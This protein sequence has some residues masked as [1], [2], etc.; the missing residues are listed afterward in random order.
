MT[1]RKERQETQMKGGTMA[2]Y[3]LG[4]GS[5][6]LVS[7]GKWIASELGGH[8]MDGISVATTKK[9]YAY[10]HAKTLL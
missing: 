3:G 5:R 2:L 9:P 6:W 1:V 7:D 4:R 10:P 8:V